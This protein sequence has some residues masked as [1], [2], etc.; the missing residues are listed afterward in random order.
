[1]E[2]EP[3][4]LRDQSDALGAGRVSARELV[5]AALRRAEAGASLGAFVALRGEQALREAQASDDRR[6][7]GEAHSKLDGVPVAHKDNLVRAGEETSCASR[8]LEGFVSPYDATVV[9]RL[10][11]AGAVVIGRTNL[12]EF[13]M[14]SSTEHSVHG[15]T[16]NP[17]DPSRSPGGSSGG[18][19]VAVAA[20]VVPGALGSDT[21]G[22]VRQPAAFTGVVGLKPTYGRV[23]RYGLVAFA[24]S[25]DQIGPFA[26]S[27][28][29]AALLLET[30]RAS[31]WVCPGSTSSRRVWT[32]VCSSGSTKRRA[33]SNA[34]VPRPA[35]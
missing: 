30:C 28:E 24:S 35:R 34:R 22:S 8:I 33:S 15:A 11:Q 31:S 32:P 16:R 12:D 18:S 20:G 23:S 4:S 25:L 27:A 29:D 6:A 26:R 10:V 19:A 9:Q 3:R 7:R 13:A 5:E 14:G 17:W 1:M 2:P 21:G